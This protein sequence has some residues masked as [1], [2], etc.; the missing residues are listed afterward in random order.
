MRQALLQA[1]RAWKKGEVPVGALVVSETGQIL[2]SAHNSPVSLDDP[3][4]HAE[5]LA[6]RKAGLKTGNYRLTGAWMFVTLEP[7]IMCAGA[8]V[9]ARLKGVIYGAGDPK[10][11]ALGSVTDI[12]EMPGINHRLLVD[13]GILEE[14]CSRL[15]KDFFRRKRENKKASV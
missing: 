6:I 2:S 15:L 4:A 7:C 8:L 3:T 13:G 14:E 1:V 10:T 5:I 12:N 9:W 11:G